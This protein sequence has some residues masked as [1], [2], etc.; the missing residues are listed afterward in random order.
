VKHY[1]LDVLS[2][3]EDLDM[4]NLC[5]DCPRALASNASSVLSDELSF[6]YFNVSLRDVSGIVEEVGAFEKVV[7][8]TADQA[9]SFLCIF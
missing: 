7:L 1:F 9:L 2:C 5:V 8:F 3:F 6:Y 4:A